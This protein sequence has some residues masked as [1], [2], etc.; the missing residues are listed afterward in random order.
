MTAATPPNGPPDADPL[1]R[2]F[3]QEYTGRFTG[4][5]RWGCSA[6]AHRDLGFCV[7]CLRDA[8]PGRPAHYAAATELTAWRLLA[9]AQRGMAAWTE[10]NPA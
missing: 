1:V 4:P 2:R 8:Q 9:M 6:V 3:L 5:M 7:P 10:P